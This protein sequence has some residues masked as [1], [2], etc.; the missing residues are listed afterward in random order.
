MKKI[1]NRYKIPSSWAWTTLDKVSEIGQGG[2]PSTI[3]PEYWDGEIPWIRSGEVRNNFITDSKDKISKLGLENSVTKLL[4]K[5]SVL[6]AMTGQ[7]LTRGRTAVLKIEACTNQSTAHLLVNKDV[8]SELY[9]FYYLRCKYWNIRTVQKGTNQPGLNTSIIKTFDIP[10][11]PK[12]EQK[13]IVAALKETF[14]KVVQV[15]QF[16]ENAINKIELLPDTILSTAFKGNNSYSKDSVIAVIDL[17]EKKRKKFLETKKGK[18]PKDPKYSEYLTI[19]DVRYDKDLPDGWKWLRL[20]DL[21]INPT[22]D[23][24]DGPFGSRLKASEYVESGTPIIRLQNID[25]N[26]FLH[27]NIKFITRNKAKELERHSFQSNDV[28]ITK[29][30][31]PVGEACIIPPELPSGIIVADVVRIRP[32]DDIVSNKFLSYVLNSDIVQKQLRQKTKGST[33]PRVNLSHI[34]D[35]KIPI[36]GR[37]EQDDLVGKIDNLFYEAK[38]IHERLL[39]ARTK[40]QDFS[41]AML[42]RAFRGTLILQDPNDEPISK[43]LDRITKN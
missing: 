18:N 31:V 27:K 22:Q 30:G 25:R 13:R 38:N 2:T 20:K 36:I 19:Q 33:R 34:R 28:V 41:K 42:F 1:V 24:V 10:I 26:K 40:I 15:Q 6:L 12:N 43:I 11:A 39:D 23:I 35:L 3:E 32:D 8:L 14:A 17:I 5:D 16:I 7:G 29:L 37:E 21:F 9:L 4:P